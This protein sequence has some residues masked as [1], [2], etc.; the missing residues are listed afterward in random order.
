[1]V[2]DVLRTSMTLSW[3]PPISDGGSPLVGY[4]IEQQD[5]IAY[6]HSWSRVDRVHAHTYSQTITNLYEGHSY[7]FRIIAENALGRSKPLETRESVT[8]K[9]P[10]GAN[11]EI[12]RN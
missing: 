3:Q 5:V 8:A 6:N 2:T 9:S 4:I 10:F 11:C 7:L 1:M 12:M